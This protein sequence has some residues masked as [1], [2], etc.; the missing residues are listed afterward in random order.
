MSAARPLRGTPE[1]TR[2]RLVDAAAQA[3]NRSGYAG[4][5]SNRIARAAGYAPGVFYKHFA[6]KK[7]IFLAVY[8]QWVAASFAAAAAAVEDASGAARLAER[9]VEIFV[10]HHRRWRGFRASLRALVQSDAEV[11]RAHRRERQ[12]QLL[13]MAEFQARRRVRA[14]AEASAL[15]MLTVERA[16]DALA[17]GEV[18]ALGLD[19][20]AFTRGLVARVR[21]W[22]DGREDGRHGGRPH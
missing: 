15:V 13:M 21:A 19:E 20:G 16:A 5:D 1:S 14:S 7:Q 4:T 8:R 3:F 22:L 10:A 12:K 9:I 6:D 18:A 11:R 17:D 2:R